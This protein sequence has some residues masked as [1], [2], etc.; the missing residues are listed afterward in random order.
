MGLLPAK[1]GTVALKREREK[2]KKKSKETLHRV[3]LSGQNYL[4][5]LSREQ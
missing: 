5:F 4:C 1:G 2:E 3:P